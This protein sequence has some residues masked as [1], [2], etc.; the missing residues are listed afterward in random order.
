MSTSPIHSRG[1]TESSESPGNYQ[2]GLQLGSVLERTAALSIS[3]TSNG[4]SGETPLFYMR[5]S[6]KLRSLNRASTQTTPVLL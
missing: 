4:A 3:Q 2:V 1:R 5:R 6:A